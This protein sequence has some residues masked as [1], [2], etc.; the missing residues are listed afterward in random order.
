MRLLARLLVFALVL[1]S[2]GALPAFAQGS[3][4]DDPCL[5]GEAEEEHTE[6]C[7]SACQCPCCPLR[8]SFARFEPKPHPEAPRESDLAAPPQRPLLAGV[9]REIFHPP[10]R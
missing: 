10:S 7:R 5:A 1:A 3:Q 8:V 4:A 6:D 2:S 9:Q